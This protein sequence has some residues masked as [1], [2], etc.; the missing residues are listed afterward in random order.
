MK[1]LLLALYR[2]RGIAF[3]PAM[4][5][6][7][8]NLF[9]P[10]LIQDAVARRVWIVFALVALAVLL[11]CFA[12]T[13]FGHR[14]LPHR[15]PRR[16]ASPVRGR[17]LGMNSPATKVPSHGVRLY[18][19]AYAIDLV[20]EPD[21]SARPEFGTGGAMRAVEEYPALGEPVF[22]MVDGVVVRASDRMRDH[23]AR[24]NLLGY[25]FMNVESVIREFGGPGF[26]F[27]NHVMIRSDD[28]VYATVAHLQR[29]SV[30]VRGGDRVRAGDRLGRCGNS[31]NSSEPHVHAQLADRKSLRIAHGLPMVFEEVVLGDSADPGD[32]VPR[33]GE[34]MI[35]GCEE[36]LQDDRPSEQGERKPSV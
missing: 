13:L 10:D 28:G 24:S 26:I 18:G 21:G 27:G 23:R 20:A 3:V 12:L 14:L 5:I 4:A 25:V 30:E 6:L 19:Q 2:T 22:A 35:A 11:L 31:G 29:G 7:L 9:V 1:R 34:H 17:W 36:Q 33:T 16:V 8:A 32:G 15:E